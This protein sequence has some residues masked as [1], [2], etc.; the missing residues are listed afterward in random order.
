MGIFSSLHLFSFIIY[1]SL[2][3]FI[4]ARN[5]KSLVK[6]VY[7]GFVACLSLWSYATIFVH[8]PNSTK[9]VAEL[10]NNIASIGWI[11]F[12]SFF[13]WFALAFAQKKALLAKKYFIP[14][15]FSFPAL[16]VPVHWL[17]YISEKYTLGVY[18]WKSGWSSSLWPVV[19]VIYYVSYM[20]VGLYLIFKEMRSSSNYAKQKQARII[21]FCTIAA[22]TLGTVSDVLIPFFDPRATPGMGDIFGLIWATGMV[23]AMARY[24]FLSIM[25]ETS[26]SNIKTTMFDCLILL[27][28]EGKIT[29]LND[30]A[31]NLLGY[32]EYELE[33]CKLT[34]LLANGDQEEMKRMLN[35]IRSSM[36]VKNRDLFFRTKNNKSIP[37]TFSSSILQDSEGNVDSIICVARDIYQQKRNETIQQVL[38]NISE[39][40]RLAVTLQ[41][42]LS[43]IQHEVAQLMDARN[44]Y[45]ALVH[46]REKAIFSFPF[47][48]DINPEELEEPDTLV[49]LPHSYTNYVLRTEKPLLADRKKYDEL[50]AKEEVH[51][52]GTLP[53]AWMGVPLK[54]SKDEAIGVV[55]VQSYSEE[56][57]F[58]E[59]D[60]EVLSIISNTIAG[61]IKFKQAE[62]ALRESEEHYRILID[63]IQDGVFLIKDEN[64]EFTNE[65]FARMVG[66][67]PEEIKHLK[68]KDFISPHDLHMVERRYHNRQEG[69]DIPAEYE[70]RMR[71]KDGYDVYVNMHVGLVTY[72]DGIASM[73]TIKDISERKK[74]ETERIE[75]EEKLARSEKMEAIGRLAGGVAHDLNNVLSGIVSYPDLLLLKLP[76]NSPYRKAVLTMQQSGQRAAAIVQDLL[77]LAR[78]GVSVKKSVNLNKI[79][80]EYVNSPEFKKLVQFHPKVDVSTNLDFQLPQI[81]GSAVHLSK[82]VMNLVSNA[83]EAMPEGGEITVVTSPKKV[84]ENIEGYY[85]TIETGD[86]VVLSIS[87]NGTGIARSD[88]DKIFDPFY[89]KKEMGRSGTGLGMS[90]VWGTVEDHKG[91]IDVN[92]IEGAGTVF[93]LYFPVTQEKPITDEMEIPMELYM[94]SG[95]K[96]LV[97]DDDPDQRD[98]ASILIKELDYKTFTVSSGEEAITY[99]KTNHADLLLLDMLMDPG[100]DGLETYREILKIKPGTKAIIVSGFSESNR[101]KKALAMGAGAY[102]K[103]PYTLEKIG[104]ILAKQFKNA[105]QETTRK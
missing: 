83:A 104:M 2:L 23:Y 57:A 35:E 80:N 101:V 78:R 19:Y 20:G 27:N 55:V 29:S 85:Q 96:I 76:P 45:V 24:K 74:A 63:N 7:I 84:T 66:R 69:Q 9:E 47:I 11:S 72:K 64:L 40:T 65:A 13:L 93:Y 102:I 48:V 77:T 94:G 86:Y 39:A 1:L 51:L 100:I 44:F 70:F 21:F 41:E 17:G 26:E 75:L 95:Q 49:K 105:S 103:K 91:F 59:S 25:P 58:S 18:G 30:A 37:V 79:I 42:L 89:T 5:P 16:L 98:I 56:S 87:D 52:I 82:T 4:L 73:G 54:T 71:H 10:F 46:D 36:N 32:Q 12:S 60:M 6:R 53:M 97:V 38:F 31:S 92:S 50:E 14:L 33:G 34:T 15:L 3:L 99:I 90:V 8:N 43:I 88:L 81:K 67:S 62:E 61:A 22:L 68:F 28:G